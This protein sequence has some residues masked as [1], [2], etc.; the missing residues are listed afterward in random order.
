MSDLSSSAELEPTKS[1]ILEVAEELFAQ[2]GYDGTPIRMIADQAQVNIAAVNYHFGSK[3]NLFESVFARRVVPM[4]RERLRRL[5]VMQGS[6]NEASVA[7]IV[8]AFI[9]PPLSIGAAKSPQIRLVQMKFLSRAFSLPDEAVFLNSY[10]REVRQR[11]IAAFRDALPDQTLATV[12]W[13]YNLM[14]G[15]LIYALAGPERML[16][17]PD[18]VDSSPVQ[19]I[20]IEA[21][22][23]QMTDFFV[24]GFLV[25]P[26]A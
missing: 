23:A 5:D 7:D 26:S 1:R 15:A 21:A 4:N 8:D 22:I 18:G 3:S 24:A 6:G 20:D 10:Y 17:A 16:R 12:L 19:E 13:R 14:V 11:Y 25:P 2:Q 9:R